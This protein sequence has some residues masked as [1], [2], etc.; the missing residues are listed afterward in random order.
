MASFIKSIDL[1]G[2]SGGVQKYKIF[3]FYIICRILQ[4]SNINDTEIP[5]TSI[6]RTAFNEQ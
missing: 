6:C 4:A 1:T 2:W 3:F 5:L